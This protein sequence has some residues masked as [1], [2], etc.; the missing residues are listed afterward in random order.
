MIKKS[1]NMSEKEFA[2]TETEGC[3]NGTVEKRIP[4]ELQMIPGGEPG[5]VLQ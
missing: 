5:G 3:P 4:E 2:M 1:E